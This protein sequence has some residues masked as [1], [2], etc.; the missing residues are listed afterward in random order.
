MARITPDGNTKVHIV[1]T[2]ASVTAPT[3]A[4]IAA[5]TELTPFLTPAGLDTPDEGQEADSSDL[6]SA[7]DKSVPSTIGGQPQGEFYRDD[8]ADDAW[9]AMPRLTT[10][11]LVIARFGGTGT[12]NAII[13]T[14][15]VEVWP[16]RVSNRN[17]VRIARGET[18]R[19]ATNFA[20]S[21]DPTLV[22]TVAA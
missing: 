4:E 17:N 21:G 9:D 15:T 7:R 1:P 13:A 11:F 14:D 2:I 3:V 12:D 10:G 18:L 19:F 8:A 6:S 5:G 16:V 22:A 20:L